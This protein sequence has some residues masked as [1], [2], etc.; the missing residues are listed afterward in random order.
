MK[1]SLSKIER[2]V[3]DMGYVP[4]RYFI[5]KK[6][7]V[8]IEVIGVKTANTFMIYIPSKYTV[9]IKDRPNI[10]VLKYIDV[11]EDGTVVN[12]YAEQ[13]DDFHLEK[14]YKQLELGMDK[15]AHMID[16]LENTYNN[17]VVLRDDNINNNKVILEIFRQLRRF[18]FCV[19]SMNYKLAI[20]Y[21][22]LMCCIR[23]DDGFQGYTI[24]NHPVGVNT[25]KLVI[26][27]DLESIYERTNNIDIDIQT[28]KH[29]INNILNK[30]QDIQTSVF[31]KLLK[32][33][34]DIENKSRM[35]YEK[36][37]KYLTYIE[38]LRKLMKRLNKEEG[39]TIE[40]MTKKS[41]EYKAKD[42]RGLQTDLEH[43]HNI[44]KYEEKLGS[45]NSIKQDI[46][47]HILTIQSKYDNINLTV[48]KVM[49][50]NAVMLDTIYS[51]LDI[52]N[53]ISV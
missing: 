9:K 29:G 7:C 14:T 24:H 41:E 17:E 53:K 8:Y 20:I 16:R 44:S 32:S 34:T 37:Q 25:R 15:D 52:L 3:N 30:N 22:N 47:K 48:D 18:R 35:I 33:R 10:F 39:Y 28:I 6:L 38:R 50:D 49:F 1:V 31:T 40:I 45:I 19:K 27:I 26:T 21:R 23:R 2:M 46:I 43:T 51:N 4:K 11:N 12:D 13:P 42:T 5:I 36:K